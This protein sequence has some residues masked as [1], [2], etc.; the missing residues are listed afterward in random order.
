MCQK[1]KK[2]GNIFEKVTL[3]L[4]RP[5]E[6]PLHADRAGLFAK[7]AAS[8]SLVGNLDKGRG[9]IKGNGILLLSL[10][11]MMMMMIFL[12]GRKR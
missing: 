5:A 7:T 3:Q 2:G 1:T 12:E 9:G 11:L 4:L 8:P 6:H 10:L